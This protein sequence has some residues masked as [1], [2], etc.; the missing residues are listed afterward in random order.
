MRLLLLTLTLALALPAR[1]EVGHA[2]AVSGPAKLKK[3][4]GDEIVLKAG[5]PIDAGDFVLTDANSTAKLLLKDRS[6]IDVSPS[7][8]FRVESLDDGDS[9]D[10]QA[11]LQEDFGKIRA[12]VNRKLGK[13]GKFLM[14][15]PSTVMAVRGTEWVATSHR[16]KNAESTKGQESITVLEGK[17]AVNDVAAKEEPVVLERGKRLNVYLEFARQKV[18]DVVRK[19]IHG[20][21]EA[22]LKRT[23]EVQTLSDA[24]MALLLRESRLEENTVA[25]LT[26][27][28][29][30]G[31]G[32]TTLSDIRSRVPAPEPLSIDTR[33]IHTPAAPPSGDRPSWR[34]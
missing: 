8:S 23:H 12:S 27:I 11:E 16:G 24:E 18:W 31:G 2:F 26:V 21:K 6:V 30:H 13:Q 25:E 9:P 20:E 22:A 17:V 15:T 28:D 4:S 3:S 14:R 1:A 29:D 34:R 32:Q 10:R 19:A 7:S 5:A 33:D